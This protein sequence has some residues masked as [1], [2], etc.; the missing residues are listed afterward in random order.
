MSG[1]EHE[2][3]EILLV[4]AVDEVITPQ[5]RRELDAHIQECESCREELADFVQIK[6]TTDSMTA[7]ILSDAA[8]EPPREPARTRAALGLGFFLM[9]AGALLLLGFAGYT[10]FSDAAVPLVIK[11]GTGVLGLG[12]LVLL[13]YVLKIRARALR[14]DPYKE[15]DQ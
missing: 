7:R 6:R 12:V 10:L 11:V 13:V 9:L 5:E 14:K 2:R 3:F 15:I 4:K 1:P 8:I